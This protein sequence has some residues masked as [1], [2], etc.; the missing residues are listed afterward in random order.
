MAYD[1]TNPQ[2]SPNPVI[3]ERVKE[4]IDS[5]I[6]GTPVAGISKNIKAIPTGVLL[7]SSEH[8]QPRYR[9]GNTLFTYT[10]MKPEG[11]LVL[12]AGEYGQTKILETSV[13]LNNI[14][15]IRYP[16]GHALAGQVIR[17]VYTE[18]GVFV[19]NETLDE[20]LSNEWVS[21]INWVKENYGV[22]A[23]TSRQY[24][25]K[26][27]P[28]FFMPVEGSWVGDYVIQAEGR[29]LQIGSDAAIAI[30]CRPKNGKLQVTSVHPITA[31]FQTKY[32]PFDAAVKR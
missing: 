31:E 17:G 21:D 14:E 20:V 1:A 25:F 19:A 3:Q 23:T 9:P 5:I 15:P 4:A 26:L 8:V 28:T 24:A 30:D 32:I 27:H 6:A 13:I 22:E 10:G 11:E 16:A 29:H 2:Y 12:E 18:A 7:A